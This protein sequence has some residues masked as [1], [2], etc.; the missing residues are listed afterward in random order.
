MTAFADLCDVADRNDLVVELLADPC[1][2]I[3]IWVMD[4]PTLKAMMRRSVVCS[5]FMDV[6]ADDAASQLIGMLAQRGYR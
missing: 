3:S 2:G 5:P 1:E 6:T 4:D